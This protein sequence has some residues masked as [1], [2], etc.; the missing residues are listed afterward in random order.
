MN[1]FYAPG[2]FHHDSMAEYRFE[3]IPT[4]AEEDRDA[5]RKVLELVCGEIIK[6]PL[7]KRKDVLRPVPLFVKSFEPI[8]SGAGFLDVYKTFL[9][10]NKIKEALPS[11]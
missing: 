9:E 7:K 1:F 6:L 5:V 3:G 10:K 8:L 11:K 4:S 2:L